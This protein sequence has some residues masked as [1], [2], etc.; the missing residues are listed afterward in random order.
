MTAWD[1]SLQRFSLR[2]GLLYFGGYLEYIDLHWCGRRETVIS[3][4]LAT[5]YAVVR[6][7]E[8]KKR[9][10]VRLDHP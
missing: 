5:W 7:A 8:P 6:Q 4:F 3:Y 2:G 1:G 9:M 10:S